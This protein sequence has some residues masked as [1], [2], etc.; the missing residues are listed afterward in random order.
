MEIEAVWLNRICAMQPKSNAARLFRR[1]IV[2]KE[3]QVE[4]GSIRYRNE[5]QR[6]LD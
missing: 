5:S 6:E 1:K 3:I 2:L 4:I